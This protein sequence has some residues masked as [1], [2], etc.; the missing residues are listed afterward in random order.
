MLA[1]GL[2]VIAHNSAGP[3]YDIVRES[4]YLADK[5]EDYAEKIKSVIQ[6]SND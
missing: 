2:L 6:A 3:K 4:R 1:A 5:K